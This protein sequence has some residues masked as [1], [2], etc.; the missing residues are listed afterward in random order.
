MKIVSK[1]SGREISCLAGRKCAFS[2]IEVTIS[3]AITAV[4]LVSLM[5]MLPAGMRIMREAGDRAVET[6]I[7]QQIL[8]EVQLTK[9]LNRNKYD[10]TTSGVWFFDDQGIRIYN[11]GSKSDPDFDFKHVYSARVSVPVLGAQLPLSLG[12]TVYQGVKIPPAQNMPAVADPNLQLVVVEI[13]SVIDDSLRKPSGF[14][15]K[16]FQKSIRT[17]QATMVKLE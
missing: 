14:S 16:G 6:R 10:S 5:G 7:Q 11:S 4:A 2:L 3:I 8:G 1:Q 12:G 9:W 15:Q 13:T 17:F